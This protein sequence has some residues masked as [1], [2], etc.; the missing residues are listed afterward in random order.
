V[1]FAARQPC[2]PSTE[3]GLGSSTSTVC[4][5]R[6]VSAEQKQQ[7]R[8]CSSSS[9]VSSTRGNDIRASAL[10]SLATSSPL[11]ARRQPRHHGAA[12]LCCSARRS[13]ATRSS[14]GP[15]A[16][17]DP[18]RTSRPVLDDDRS[19][20]SADHGGQI[21]LSDDGNPCVQ[22]RLRWLCALL[23]GSMLLASC[24]PGIYQSQVHVGACKTLLRAGSSDLVLLTGQ[25]VPP[26]GPMPRRRRERRRREPSSGQRTLETMAGRSPVLGSDT[27]S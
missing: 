2:Q 26:P 16:A 23:H 15:A 13:R 27:A 19:V 1:P 3:L 17:L 24:V 12:R 5:R 8:R 22:R 18:M 14:S 20:G 9:G 11:A 6:T 10:A 7:P 25:T 4:Q 21:V